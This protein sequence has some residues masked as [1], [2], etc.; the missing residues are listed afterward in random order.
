METAKYMY[1]MYTYK[2]D[3][4]AGITQHIISFYKFKS[5]KLKLV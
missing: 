5:F 1:S 3:I 2:P 4:N